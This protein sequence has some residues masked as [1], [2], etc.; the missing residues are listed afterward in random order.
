MAEQQK[1]TVLHVSPS[2]K[3]AFG[4]GGPILSVARL[5]EAAHDGPYGLEPLVFTTTANGKKELDFKFKGK[6]IIDG[7]PVFFYARL[8]GDHTHFSPALLFALHRNLQKARTEKQA[9]LVHIHSW[10][11]LVAVLSAAV[12]LLHRVPIIISPRGM[13]TNY[14][15][16]FRNTFL[17]QVIHNVLGKYILKKAMLHATTA[18]EAED[19]RESNPA[20]NIRVIPNLLTTENPRFV[21]AE[22]RSPD[23]VVSAH[24]TLEILEKKPRLRLL[25]LSR[26]DQ[27]K[28]LDILFQAL[29][30]AA[31]PWTL[32]I[33]GA[34]DARYIRFLKQLS[35]RHNISR[36]VKWVGQVAN[37]SKYRLMAEHDLLVLPSSNENFGNVVLESLLVGTAVLLSDKVGLAPYISESK[38]GWVCS[39]SPE[40]ITQQLSLANLDLEKRLH[41]RKCG[42]E[43][44]RSDFCT[45]A[46]MKDYLDLYKSTMRKHLN[47]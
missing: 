14:T 26:I 28:G 27:K 13:I 22:Q 35:G 33:A 8:T 24:N 34:G 32:T 44:V 25:F 30:V 21:V 4:Y 40:A 15:R 12:T 16:S 38:L 39:P 5:C 1:L 20:C 6:R 9:I 10:W 43:Q 2:Y 42:A 31:F 36:Q 37:D 19:I 11:N 18:L 3:P 41:I 45:D 17:K 23:T 7:V 47:R 46:I 29:S